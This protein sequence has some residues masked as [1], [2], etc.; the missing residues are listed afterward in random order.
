MAALCVLL[1]LVLI[2]TKNACSVLGR[3]DVTS[4]NGLPMGSLADLEGTVTFYDR[5]SGLM[6]LQQDQDAVRVLVIGGA[7]AEAGHR[8][9]VR[10]RKSPIYGADVRP[11]SFQLTEARI[12]GERT[13]VMPGT[14]LLAEDDGDLAIQSLRITVPGIVQDGVNQDG[15]LLLK[16]FDGKRVVPVTVLADEFVDLQ[17]L[18]DAEVAVTGVGE[19]KYDAKNQRDQLSQILV[20]GMSDVVVRTNPPRDVPL[21][22]TSKMAG[23]APPVN[24]GHRIRVRG[25]VE[26]QQQ[27]GSVVLFDGVCATIVRPLAPEGWKSGAVVEA[28]GFPTRI[29]HS[30]TLSYGVIQPLEQVAQQKVAS[31]ATEHILTTVADIRQLTPEQA[32]QP[33]PVKIEGVVTFYHPYLHYF[34]VQDSTAGIFVDFEGQLQTLAVGQKILLQGLT[35]PGF[36]APIIRHPYVTVLGQEK[37]PQPRQLTIESAESGGQDSQWVEAEGIVHPGTERESDMTFALYSP[38]GVIHVTAPYSIKRS[39]IASLVDAHVRMRGPF[40]TVFNQRRQIIG[41]QMFL[42]GAEFVQVLNSQTA[43]AEKSQPLLI[44]DL[45]RFSQVS[46]DAQHRVKVKGTVVMSRTGDF[47]YMQDASGGLQVQATGAM[48]QVGDVVEAIG[49]PSSGPYSPVLRDAVLKKVGGGESPTAKPISPEVAIRGS[50]DNQLVEMQARLLSIGTGPAGKTLILQADSRTFNAQLDGRAADSRIDN[51]REGSMLRLT[52]VCSVETDPRSLD[53]IHGSKPIGFEL[54]LRSSEDVQIVQNAPWLTMQRGLVLLGVLSVV[55]FLILMWATTLRRRVRVQ[56][57]DLRQAKELAESNA[58]ALLEANARMQFDSTHDALTGLLN[59]P[60]AIV[61][62]NAEIERAK[63]EGTN[64]SV[65]LVDIDHFKKV[66]DTF[67]HLQGDT[68]L[69]AVAHTMQSSLRIYDEMGRYGGEEFLIV[70]PGT[71]ATEAREIGERLRQGVASFPVE[72]FGIGTRITISVGFTSAPEITNFEE[73][74]ILAAA[75]A[76]LYRAKANGR[77]RVESAEPQARA[78]SS[79]SS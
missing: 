46:S 5:R 62:L 35:G 27:D 56:T 43:S 78:E 44:S 41:Y 11:G 53:P 26:K 21:W 57:E 2:P 63:R 59:R 67:G 51:I 36:F 15:R 9:L 64:L 16:L 50:Y 72:K 58:K 3:C 40:G 38:I 79:A 42:P 10:G 49:Y 75:D 7:S 33:Y 39:A 23:V 71:C 45:M 14:R 70:L 22:S 66:N 68:A 32:N 19:W 54:L 77:N 12:S 6:Y 48:P 52:G 34:F 31:K 60:A 61:R 69:R 73:T 18:V 24:G 17:K 55:A 37:L 8:I 1:C 25:K 28:S 13:S 76:A 29:T 20:A 47:V 65:L 4:L 30:V 74:P